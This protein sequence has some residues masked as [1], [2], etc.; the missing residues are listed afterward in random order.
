MTLI[1]DEAKL[2][3]MLAGKVALYDISHLLPT[4]RRKY[5]VR[6]FSGIVRA[7]FHHSGADGEQG[8]PGAYNSAKYV[9]EDRQF[10][11]AAYHFWFPYE[12][13][14]DAAGNLVL[15][16]MNK[17]E[18]R[19]YHTG[20]KANTHGLGCVFQGN[21]SAKPMSNYQVELAEAFVPWAVKKY[22]LALDRTPLSFHAEAGKFGG[23]P[24]S[25]CPGP[26]VTKWV[27]DY[28]EHM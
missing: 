27:T 16:R 28:R 5:S 13:F 6:S 8:Y 26:H 1:P 4:G 22:P 20:S 12:Y 15:F 19:S 17:D 25:S 18:T 14:T 10:R 21:L 2:E 24:K 7:Y 3:T 23:K 9:V 11:G